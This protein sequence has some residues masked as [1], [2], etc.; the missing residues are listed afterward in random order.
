MNLRGIRHRQPHSHTILHPTLYPTLHHRHPYNCT[1]TIS[2]RNRI[3]QPLR[4]F[5]R[6]GQNRLPPLLHNQRCLR[7]NPPPLYPSNTNTTLTQPPKR[8]R[9]LHSSRPIKH[10]PTH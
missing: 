7:P 6:L 8:P 1:P 4:D 10:S 5:L 2:T 3:K 9:Q